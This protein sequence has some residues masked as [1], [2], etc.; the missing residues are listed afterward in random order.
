MTQKQICLFV[1]ATALA[2]VSGLGVGVVVLPPPT[3]DL[4]DELSRLQS[5]NT[6]QTHQLAQ[7]AKDVAQLRDT[8]DIETQNRKKAENI[9]LSLQEQLTSLHPPVPVT[10]PKAKQPV[11]TVPVTSP[12]AKQPVQK[13]LNQPALME[14]KQTVLGIRL[15]Q[16][17]ASVRQKYSLIPSNYYFKDTDHPGTIWNISQTDPTLK[18]VRLYEYIGLI[19]QVKAEF[20]DASEVNFHAVKKMI[21]DKYDPDHKES[22]TDSLFGEIHLTASIDGIKVMISVDWDDKIFDDDTLTI[23]Y[24]HEY[25]GSLCV[26]EIEQIKA[27]KIKNS[28]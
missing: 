27:S 5:L 23:T 17:L 20:V 11:Q 7:A 8:V 28:L 24:Q 18:A 16:S 14:T 26:Q 15:G 22:L 19:Y 2:F 12:K 6:K 13:P 21:I 9:V 25:L 3:S 1:T 10:S 4:Q